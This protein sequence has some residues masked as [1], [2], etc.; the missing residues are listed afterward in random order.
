MEAA[1]GRR[2]DWRSASTMPGVL[3]VA[4]LAL[5]LLR[6]SVGSLACC[7]VSCVSLCVSSI[8]SY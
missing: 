4:W 1:A 7:K 2:V 8:D 5:L 3:F 6:L